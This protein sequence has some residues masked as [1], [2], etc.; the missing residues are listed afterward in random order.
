VQSARSFLLKLGH[1]PM[2]IAKQLD[3][4]S[5][6]EVVV[7]HSEPI[8]SEEAGKAWQRFENGQ[9]DGGVVPMRWELS[10]QRVFSL[11]SIIYAASRAT[12][13]PLAPQLLLLPIG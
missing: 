5:T 2:K 1:Q 11:A 6:D 12:T 3:N 10:Y 4:G 8:T 7:V 13:L 9:S